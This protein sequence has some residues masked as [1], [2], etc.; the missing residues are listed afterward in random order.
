MSQY[1]T[2]Y[3]LATALTQC[4]REHYINNDLVE[5]D[6]AFCQPEETLLTEALAEVNGVFRGL[7]KMHPY[8]SG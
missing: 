2:N 4:S 3:T 1:V 6:S 5:G 7:T 8:T